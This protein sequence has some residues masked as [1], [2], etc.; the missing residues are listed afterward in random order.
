MS[1]LIVGDSFLHLVPSCYFDDSNGYWRVRVCGGYQ[2]LHRIVANAKDGEIVD[3]INRDKND[4]RPENLRIVSK[5]LNNYNKPIN[6]SLGRGIYF[7]SY[8]KRFRAC[9]SFMGKTLKLGSFNNVNDAKAAYNI[10]AREIYGDDAY[11]H[12]IEVQK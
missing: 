1:K 12:Q 7:D 11:Q 5:S 3:H 4:N 8:G 10:K 6:N 2:Y 9:I